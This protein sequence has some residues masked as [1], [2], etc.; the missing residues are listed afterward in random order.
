MAIRHRRAGSE[1]E[2]LRGVLGGLDLQALVLQILAQSLQP[3]AILVNQRDCRSGAHGSA[4][5]TTGADD[6]P[7]VR[8]GSRAYCAVTFTW[9]G[10]AASTF[11]KRMVKTPFLQLAS[12]LLLSIDS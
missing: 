3:V 11:G 8:P 2:R 4:P 12:I 9:R 7:I 1:I 10:R 6:A 5:P